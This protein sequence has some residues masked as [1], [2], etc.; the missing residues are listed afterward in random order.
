MSSAVK[1]GLFAILCLLVLAFF[2]MRIE[3]WNLFDSGGATVEARFDSV[4]GLDDKAPVRVAGVRV[5]RVD[6]L[7][8]DGSRALLTLRLE[9]PLALTEGTTAALASAG[10]LGEKYVE[11]VPGPPDAPLLAAGAVL[12]GTTP[13]SFD[14]A[15]AKLNDVADS[16]AGI[17]GSIRGDGD[18]T[19]ISRLIANLEAVSAEIRLLVSANREQIN[20]TVANFERFSTTLADELPR[21]VS[22]IERVLGQVDGVVAENRENL[23]GSLANVEQLTSRL[24]TS[25]D[26]LNVITSKIASGEGTLGKLVQS[27]E[28]HDSLVE[29]LGS[30]D[31][32]V[33]GLSDTLGRAQKLG[34]E[35]G[36]EG[37]YLQEGEESRSAFRLDVD[38]KSGRFYRVEVVDDPRGRVHRKTREDVTTLPDGS[39][40]TTVTRTTITEEETSLS[41]QFGFIFGNARVRAGLFESTGGA[42]FDYQFFDRR[43][44]LSLEAFD[45]GR[46]GEIEGDD[47]RPRLRVTGRYWVHPSVYLMGGYDDALERERDSLFLGA[48]VRW[49]DDD[50]KY[51]LGSI[52]RF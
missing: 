48:G 27:D 43:L 52:P 20:S 31:T 42:G 18:D 13:M 33:K 26:N 16:V 29:T 35:L 4:A 22:Q 1:V 19:P 30:I 41:A 21:L 37:A 45:F 6:G 3:D 36:F 51:L 12:E 46:E 32:G 7:R 24:Q 47:L 2:V 40:E 9:Q 14:E 44:L 34:M 11:I 25:V 15:M 10:L 8:L 39:V 50:L 49:T 17:T 23:R 28:A 38:P 5:G